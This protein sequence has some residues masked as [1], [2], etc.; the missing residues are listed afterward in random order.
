MKIKCPVC[1]L[2][3]EIEVELKTRLLTICKEHGMYEAT[4]NNPRS[5]QLTPYPCPECQG[6]YKL[7]DHHKDGYAV[8][9]CEKHGEYRT[10][11]NQSLNFRRFCSR[12]A[13]KPNKSPTYF[14]PPELKVK[15]ALDSLD[16]TYTHNQRFKARQ[17]VYY[18]PDFVVESKKLVIGVDPSI[19]HSRWNRTKSDKRKIAYFKDL[20]YRYLSLPEDILNNREKLITTL[21]NNLVDT[22]ESTT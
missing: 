9:Y 12:I 16:I 14:T 3:H 7:P 6:N 18:Y 5:T 13:R 19:W 4:R 17:G 20:G 1:G 15:K 22:D 8:C 21:E 10:N 11:V 2:F